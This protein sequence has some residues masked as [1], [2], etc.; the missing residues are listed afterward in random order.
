MTETTAVTSVNP[1]AAIQIGTAGKPYS[2]TEIK[3]VNEKGDTVP[4]GWTGELCVR[5]PQVMKEYWRR[6]E[7]TA[8]ALDAGGWLHTGDI[9]IQQEDDYLRIVDRINDMILVAGHN[10]SPNEV[11]TVVMGCQ[12]VTECAVVGVN[13]GKDGE[14]VKL[15]VVIKDVSLT[16]AELDA[17]CRTHLAVHKIPKFIEFRDDLPKNSV[18]TILRRE[19]RVAG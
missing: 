12:G 16:A 4:R 17:H 5:G 2:D 6:P 8:R 14:Q 1:V 7:A 10:V 19:L 15:F 9:A 13:D 3:I 11:E 18:G